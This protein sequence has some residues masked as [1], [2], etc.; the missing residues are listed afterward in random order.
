MYMKDNKKIIRY[1]VENCAFYNTRFYNW[2][3]ND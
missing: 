1:L 3:E 2:L